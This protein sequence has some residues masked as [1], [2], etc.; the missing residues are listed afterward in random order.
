[1]ATAGTGTTK[2]IKA[3]YAVPL[4][5]HAGLLNEVATSALG[6]KQTRTYFAAA[7]QT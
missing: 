3:Q 6:T 1:V 4:R 2:Q 5:S 7:K